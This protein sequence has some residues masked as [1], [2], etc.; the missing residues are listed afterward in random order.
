M[1]PLAPP[2]ASPILPLARLLRQAGS[3]G[4]DVAEHGDT[5]DNQQGLNHVLIADQRPGERHGG[6]ADGVEGAFGGTRNQSACEPTLVTLGF[7]A[8]MSKLLTLS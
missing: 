2:V 5:G 6:E 7:A 1:V 3:D 4:E 8:M